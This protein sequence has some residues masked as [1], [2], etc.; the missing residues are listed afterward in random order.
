MQLS[1]GR[2]EASLRIEESRLGPSA[3]ER[4]QRAL[5]RQ[6]QDGSLSP[7]ERQAEDEVTA[8]EEELESHQLDDL[9]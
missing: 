9:A 5:R 2:L 8:E 6:R 1:T 7:T 3:Q 4:R